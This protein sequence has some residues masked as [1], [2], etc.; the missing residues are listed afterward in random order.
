MNMPGFT[1]EASLYRT[2]NTYQAAYSTWPG[3]S[4]SEVNMS[5]ANLSYIITPR[6]F[7]P[8]SIPPDYL[9]YAAC[10]L[11]TFF[12]CIAR[13]VSPGT[14]AD[15]AEAVCGHHLLECP[16]GRDPCGGEC[17]AI[18]EICRDGRCIAVCPPDRRVCPERQDPGRF[19]CCREGQVCCDGVCCHLFGGEFC[20]EGA[21]YST[22]CGP[23]NAGNPRY[24]C[25]DS[26]GHPHC[27]YNH[28]G[29]GG[30]RYWGCEIV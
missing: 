22:C 7:P 30:C 14:C 18:N 21:Y 17:C 26:H 3:S 28:Q 13:G 29:I 12:S 11:R 5:E 15:L 4:S 19:S 24:C 23:D 1:A 9:R 10:W 20:C 25:I 16:D 8:L 2:S 6:T 27:C